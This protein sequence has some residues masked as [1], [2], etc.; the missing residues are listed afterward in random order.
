MSVLFILI[1]AVVFVSVDNGG[2]SW[3]GLLQAA[4]G[5]HGNA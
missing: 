3:L 5:C 4:Q 2:S 1:M